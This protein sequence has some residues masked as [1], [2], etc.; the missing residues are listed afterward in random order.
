MLLTNKSGFGLK[1]SLSCHNNKNK[2][3]F[4]KSETKKYTF[5]LLQN[6]YML[7]AQYIQKHNVREREHSN[8]KHANQKIG[9]LKN[10]LFQM[11]QMYSKQQ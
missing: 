1:V 6:S 4:N 5:Y 8:F 2:F 3:Q 7:L 11:F 9:G 10:N